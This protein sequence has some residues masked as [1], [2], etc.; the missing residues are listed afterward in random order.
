MDAVSTMSPRPGRI[1]ANSGGLERTRLGGQGVGGNV[2]CGSLPASDCQLIQTQCDTNPESPICSILQYTG[3]E[4]SVDGF[5]YDGGEGSANYLDLY[6]LFG[7]YSDI[8]GDGLWENHLTSYAAPIGYD[9]EV[10]DCINANGLVVYV[11]EVPLPAGLLLMMSA[12]LG[13]VG[14]KRLV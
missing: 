13:L 8:D 1:P 14:M 9:C 3:G 12:L 11:S 2:S 7:T 6:E 5:A 4:Y 10:V